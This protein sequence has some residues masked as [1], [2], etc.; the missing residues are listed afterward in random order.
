MFLDFYRLHEQ[1]FG[2][3][4]DPRFLYLSPTHREA[5]ASLF[6]GV[7]MGRGFLAMIAPPGMGKTTL[8]LRLLERLRGSAYTAFLFQTQCDSREFFRLLLADL[9]IECPKQDMVCMQEALNQA[10]IRLKRA[11]RRFVLVI[12]EA[13]NLEDSVL[14]TVR[15]LSNFETPGAKLMQIIISGQPQLAAKLARPCLLQLRQR[16]AILARLEPLAQA[17]VDRYIDDRLQ[18]AGYQGGPLFTP[19][20]RALIAARSRGIP[21]NINNLCFNALTMGYALSRPKIDE[22]IVREVILD[23]ELE[24]LAP[25]GDPARR[26]VSPSRPAASPK[27]L[28]AKRRS[29]LAL[30]TLGAA[31][32]AVSVTLGSV[33]LFPTGRRV[34]ANEIRSLVS[35]RPTPLAL[36]LW[37]RHPTLHPAVPAAAGSDKGAVNEGAAIA[38]DR[39]PVPS[40]ISTSA[41]A[42]NRAVGDGTLK[43]AAPGATPTVVVEVKPGQGLEQITIR[44]F[45]RFD[46]ELLEEIR[47][48]NPQI[49]D[50]DHLEVGQRIVLPWRAST[51]PGTDSGGRASTEP[52]S[53]TRN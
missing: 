20:A 21:R 18:V 6:Y 52:T 22:E 7:E 17:E 50:I 35:R 27:P 2:V 46:R 10:L 40:T 28:P 9:G 49:T 30:R 37:L 51:P 26:L 43:D 3:T 11:N 33:A 38:L 42:R 23:L 44:H 24:S 1:P 8:L 31:A 53:S 14:E 25:E 34:M 12:D 36:S 16:I 5:L 15:L 41:L 39:S 29:M 48:L 13:Q 45:G 19:G 4:P 32:L 47:A